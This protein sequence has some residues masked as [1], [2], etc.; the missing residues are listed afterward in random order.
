LQ[1]QQQQSVI[2]NAIHNLDY[3]ENQNQIISEH[4]V[5]Q[6]GQANFNSSSNGNN[7][8]YPTENIYG[9]ASSTSSSADIYN[10]HIEP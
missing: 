8:F 4:P 2:N 10:G 9:Q 5:Q 3:Y 1:Q 6:N 7:Y